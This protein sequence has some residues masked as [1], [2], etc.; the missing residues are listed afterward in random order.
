MAFHQRHRRLHALEQPAPAGARDRER[1]P[2]LADGIGKGAQ[3]GAGGE[4]RERARVDLELEAVEQLP[5]QGGDVRS[6]PRHG[7]E[8]HGVGHLVEDHPVGEL[9]ALD[10]HAGG[11]RGEVRRDEQ[12]PRGDRRVQQLQLVLPEHAPADQAEQHADLGRRD[13]RDPRARGTGERPE[14]L[15]DAAQ[16]GIEQRARRGEVRRRPAAAMHPLG[17]G[18]RRRGPE[19]GH[20][21]DPLRGAIDPPVQVLGGRDALARAAG[22]QQG[23]AFG[24]RGVDHGDPTISASSASPSGVRAATTGECGTRSSGAPSAVSQA[25]NATCP[26]LSRTMSC[27]AATSTARQPQ[28]VSMPS[29]R[30]S[31][32]WH[33]DTAIVPIARMR[34]TLCAQPLDALGD[35]ARAGRL[36]RHELERPGLGRRSG[37]TSTSGGR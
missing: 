24:E 4:P 20:L 3:V 6:Q 34:W 36:Q 29:T 5:Q 26:P 18:Q 8:L 19:P 7:G 35:P 33:I 25:G 27:A 15:A 9:F 17:R 37:G 30:A 1:Q 28:S 32:T 13:V 2:A 11:H 31:A 16:Q 22:E 21:G 10:V 14:A 23:K 12:Q